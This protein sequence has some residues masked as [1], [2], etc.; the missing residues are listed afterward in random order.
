MVLG[1][2]G[3][4]TKIILDN[5]GYLQKS[6]LNLSYVKNALGESFQEFK[7]KKDEEILKQK[8]KL[9]VYAPTDKEFAEAFGFLEK[10]QKML[11]KKKKLFTTQNR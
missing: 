7:R 4:E 2:R 3:G 11:E 10:E 5:G 9:S 1:K 6:F 8:K